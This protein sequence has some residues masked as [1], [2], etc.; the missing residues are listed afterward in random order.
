[1]TAPRL[2]VSIHDVAPATWTHCQRLLELVAR[3]FR[4]PCTLLVVPDYH[5]SGRCDLDRDFRQAIERRLR[6][7][8]DVALHGY[9]H[10]DEAPP[11][12]SFG[13]W[14]QRRVLTAS[15]AKFAGLAREDAARR[16]EQGRRLFA[17]QGWPTR[18][19]VPPAWQFGPGQLEL[20]REAG[21]GWT[22]TRET[23]ID[24]HSG[25]RCAAPSLTCSVRSP[26]RR[27][28]SFS[29]LSIGDRLYAGHGRLRLALHPADARHPPVVAAW[30]RLLERLRRNREP[31]L[32]GEWSRS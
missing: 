5:R 2:A 4:G 26:L 24:L 7:G 32:E 22:T 8:D 31:Q 29:W 3:S 15:E 17:A 27:V 21:F 18:G 12:R 14:I 9:F 28:A 11:P 1:M 23:V 6:R 10:W 20:L 16:L 13:G 30:A 25:A 19:F